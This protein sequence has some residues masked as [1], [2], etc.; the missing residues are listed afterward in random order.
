MEEGKNT[1]TIEYE[2]GSIKDFEKRI[3]TEGR[4]ESFLPVSFVATSEKET[5]FYNVSGYHKLADLK[6]ENSNEMMCIL[7]KCIFALI[8]SGNYLLNAKK[9]LL[10]AE[11]VFFSAGGKELR[12]A[13]VPRKLP[14]ESAILVFVEFL[15]ELGKKVE[16]KEQG[17]Y[18]KAV[19]SYIEYNNCSL[20]DV[21][22][23]IGELKQEIHAC[24]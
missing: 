2:R 4:C 19:V 15:A 14:T 8:E 23:C 17:D 7:E 21:I 20:F 9:L 10:S 1:F 12:F 3:L 6:I 11:T 18:L 13:Y 5:A 16:N 24:G 22:N